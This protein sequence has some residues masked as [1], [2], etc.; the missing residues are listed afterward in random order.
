MGRAHDVTQEDRDTPAAAP[1]VVTDHHRRGG[2]PHVHLRRRD[3]PAVDARH[4]RPGRRP[5]AGRSLRRAAL[6]AAVALGIGLP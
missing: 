3:R 1:V 5:P 2:T 4:M 6:A